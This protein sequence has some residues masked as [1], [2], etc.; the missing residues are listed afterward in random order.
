MTRPTYAIRLEGVEAF[1][2]PVAVLRDLSDLLAEGA[3]RAARLAVEGRSTARGT[4]P[5]WA[6]SVADV[7][8]VAF[9]SGSLA[10][11]V[12]APR[13]I[14]AAPELFR[15]PSLFGTSPD[16]DASALDLLLDAIDDVADGRRDSDRLDAGVL[17][18]LAQSN[19]LFTRGGTR[20]TVERIGRR[21]TT[22]D[23]ST[24]QT[25]RKFANETP[26]A[27]AARVR[28][29]LDT[30][31]V[32]ARAVVVRLD[33]GRQLRGFLGGAPLDPLRE[34]LGKNVVVEG[35]TTYRPSGD[36]LRMEIDHV[37][38]ATDR[39]RVWARW[40]RVEPS[41]ARA[42]NPQSGDGIGDTFGAWPGDETDEEIERLLAEHS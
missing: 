5:T 9:T 6:A 37:A 23:A 24:A 35:M 25:V 22:F 30:I 1:D 10:L 2:L 36:P 3:Q 38:P 26:A 39:D 12:E 40:P 7:R 29:L 4:A 32:T 18:L 31:S 15:Q 8:V 13:L 16:E 19:A 42:R 21:V 28:G 27:R 33:D 14:D 17:E 20:L 34:L 11:R 41:P